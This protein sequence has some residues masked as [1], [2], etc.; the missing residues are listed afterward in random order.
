MKCRDC[1]HWNN[2]EDG[3]EVTP[4]PDGYGSCELITKGRYFENPLPLAET[5]FGYDLFTKPDFG[6]VLFESGKRPPDAT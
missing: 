5:A 2:D 4:T 6:C 3:G 1:K